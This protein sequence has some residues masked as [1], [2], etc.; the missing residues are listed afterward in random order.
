MLKNLKD[1]RFLDDIAF[2][3]VNKPKYFLLFARKRK[4]K[5]R[6]CNLR[7]KRKRLNKF[8]LNCTVTLILSFS[9]AKNNLI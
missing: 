5:M 2:K 7:L 9:E 1:Q 3:C 6:I 8:I 4:S